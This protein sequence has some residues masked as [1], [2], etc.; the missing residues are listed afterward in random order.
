M[1]LSY[2]DQLEAMVDRL[3]LSEVTQLVADIA[4]LKAEH[5]ASAWQDYDAARRWRVAA[6]RIE[7][8]AQGIRSA[9]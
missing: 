6:G 4:Y 5:L 8:V 9:V 3:G 2:Q 7:R 1:M